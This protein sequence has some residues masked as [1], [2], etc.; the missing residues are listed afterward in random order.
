MANIPGDDDVSL[1]T[2]NGFMGVT[3]GGKVTFCKHWQ[4]RDG[5]CAADA[6]LCGGER[7]GYDDYYRL[8]MLLTFILLHDRM[9]MYII[10]Y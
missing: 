5:E 9:N 6:P 10:A 3:E 2:R 7:T 4:R 1:F 8:S